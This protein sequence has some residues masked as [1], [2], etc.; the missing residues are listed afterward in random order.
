M[1][2]VA[3]VESRMDTFVKVIYIKYQNVKELEVYVEMA[4]FSLTVTL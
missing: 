1:A 3:L 2:A 4:Y